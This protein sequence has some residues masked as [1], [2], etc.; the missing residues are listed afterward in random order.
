M[1]KVLHIIASM[2]PEKGGVSQAVRNL[3]PDLQKNNI[4]SEALSFDNKD[5][6]YNDIFPVYNIGPAKSPYQY[7]SDLKEWLNHNI[8]NYDIIIIHGLWLYNTYGSYRV[9]SR[10]NKE[11]RPKLYVM[12]H[13][14]LD[15][16]FQKAKER[17][18]KAIRNKLIWALLE[19]KVIN[20]ADGILFTC[21][22]ELLLA[23]Q[24]FKPYNPKNAYNVGLGIPLPPEYESSMTR[25]FKSQ[26]KLDIPNEGYLLFLSRIN[27]KKG[28]DNLIN[29]YQE[30]YSSI[31]LPKLII[32]GPGLDTV[33]GHYVKKL[34]G[35]NP[36]IIFTG[37]LNGDAKWAAIYNCEAFILPSHQENFGIAV[38]EAM[39]CEKPVLITNKINIYKEIE[40]SNAGLIEND[41]LDGAKQLLLGWNRLSE[42][43]RN[44][45]AKNALKCFKENFSAEGAAHKMASTLK[46]G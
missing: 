11:R 32:A 23:K 16:Y 28:I 6:S 27:F 30:L 36:N 14:M 9:W 18:L 5:S 41:D 19:K 34:A 31:N 45:M 25:G 33:F 12:P 22:Q 43:D 1:I 44:V 29:A 13:G 10:L 24:N 39:A 8:M 35:K 38:V 20:N 26:C 37:M 46:N 4:L 40:D 3:I 2:D 42:D 21:E 7:T 15:P 17:K